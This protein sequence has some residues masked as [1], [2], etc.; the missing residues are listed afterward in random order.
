MRRFHCDRWFPAQ[1]ESNMKNLSI[2]WRHNGLKETMRARVSRYA[3]THFITTIKQTMLVRGRNVDIPGWFLC[4]RWVR[5]LRT[6]TPSVKSSVNSMEHLVSAK[7]AHFKFHGIP[8]NCSC[9]WNWRTP[10]SMEFP[11]TDR[12]IEN[13]ACQVPWNSLECSCQRN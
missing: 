10:S 2:W 7:L 9:Q 11:G 6:I 12:V 3:N 4:Y 1:K 13:G 8:W 5:F